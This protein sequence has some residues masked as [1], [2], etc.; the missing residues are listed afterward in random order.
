MIC[1]NAVG[2]TLGNKHGSGQGTL[3]LDNVRCTGDE[4]NVG[5]CP[6]NGWGVSN[7]TH[8]EDVSISCAVDGKPF[9]LDTDWFS[10]RHNNSICTDYGPLKWQ[11]YF[12]EH[13]INYFKYT[14]CVVDCKLVECNNSRC[15][16][17]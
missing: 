5:E 17:T 11:H 16:Q 13:N 9:A 6:H 1:R 8:L 2:K 10:M 14:A 15:R 7:C 3:W 4:Q 12:V